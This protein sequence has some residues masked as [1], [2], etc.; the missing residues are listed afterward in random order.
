MKKPLLQSV[1][2]VTVLA[3]VSVQAAPVLQISRNGANIELKWPAA[4][5]DWYLQTTASLKTGPWSPVLQSS[6][7]VSGNLV[8]TLAIKPTPRFF[9][10]ALTD[11]PD[12]AHT[13]LN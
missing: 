2:L 13:D 4:N 11:L 8:T 1:A 9:R 12:S 7:N 6:A 5:A 10:L 3:H